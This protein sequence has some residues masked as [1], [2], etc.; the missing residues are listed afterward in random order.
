MAKCKALTGPVVKG[1]MVNRT[2]RDDTENQCSIWP[3]DGER[4][5]EQTSG[6]LVVTASIWSPQGLVATPL[7]HGSAMTLSRGA[8]SSDEI[9]ACEDA[10]LAAKAEVPTAAAAAGFF[11]FGCDTQSTVINTWVLDNT[12]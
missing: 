4:R 10:L 9:G 8:S 3:G 1:L 7:A 5:E 12:N 2:V 11:L 6:W